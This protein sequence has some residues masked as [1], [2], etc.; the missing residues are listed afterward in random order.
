MIKVRFCG[1]IPQNRQLTD[2]PFAQMSERVETVNALAQRA[3]RHRLGHRQ[4][5]VHILQIPLERLAV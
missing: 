5:R 1:E 2:F 4:L 3:H